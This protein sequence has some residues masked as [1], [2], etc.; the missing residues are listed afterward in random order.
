MTL[1]ACEGG[2]WR[3]DDWRQ[4]SLR[5]QLGMTEEEAI[6]AIGFPPDSAEMR[7]C[8]TKT[9]TSGTCRIIAYDGTHDLQIIEAHVEGVWLVNS[10]A[11]Y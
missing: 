1:A 3:P 9:E 5:L 7:T 11:V 6:T 8:G 2:Q 4:A 10:W